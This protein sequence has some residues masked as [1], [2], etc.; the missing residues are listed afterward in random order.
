MAGSLVI[1]D[2]ILSLNLCVLITLTM[3]FFMLAV[4]WKKGEKPMF[5]ACII[6]VALIT[7]NLVVYFA[8]P[9]V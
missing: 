4:I 2:S 7:V 5:F 3:L 9:Y 6:C 1:M 8:W